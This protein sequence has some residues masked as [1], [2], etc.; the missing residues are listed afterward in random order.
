MS[1]DSNRLRNAA[2]TAPGDGSRIGGS[3]PSAVTS[4]QTAST[5]MMKAVPSTIRSVRAPICAA[6]A[7]RRGMPASSRTTVV[8][9]A[10]LLLAGRKAGGRR[11]EHARDL[12]D[13]G[14]EF[15]LEPRLVARF[16]QIDARLVHD[17][18]RP[19][20]EHADAV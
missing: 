2:T 1:G 11:P 18:A 13:I 6:P 4:H 15:R 10:S 16:W 17:A 8:A 9:M 19:P 14:E 5:K 7:G 12:A 20:A 3:R